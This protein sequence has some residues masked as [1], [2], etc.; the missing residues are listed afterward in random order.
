M[1]E[2]ADR[3]D[4]SRYY[5]LLKDPNRRRIIELLGSRGRVG[6]K[7]LREELGVAVGTI[8]YHL[9]LLSDFITQDKQRKY[10]L[11]D[12]GRLL[13]QTLQRGVIPPTIEVREAFRH[14][15]T[16]WILLSPIYART[17]HPW[18][19]VPPAL[20]TLALGALG[21]ALAGLEPVL[22]FF[23]PSTLSFWVIAL[24]FILQWVG[25]FLLAWFT[26]YLLHRRGE[27]ALQL[28]TCVGIS[29]LPYALFPYVYLL[30]PHH[31]TRLL[32]PILQVWGML[33][34]SVALCFGGGMRLSRSVT[35][36]LALLYLNVVIL[37][38][39]RRI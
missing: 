38:L 35:V 19:M 8:Y 13:Y 21:S 34:L 3:G 10:M 23:F 1:S 33:L 12:Q 37:I 24:Q 29:A 28:F 11:N 7:E 27:G 4:L 36:S 25:V 16:R 6:F 20:L 30:L 5:A 22:F 17:V 39:L 2:K 31:L 32:L 14:R 18:R 9:E 15:L 26:A